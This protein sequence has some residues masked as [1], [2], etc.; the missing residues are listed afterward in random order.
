MKVLHIS[1]ARS[2]GGN[3]QQLVDVL[4]ELEKLNVQNLVFGIPQ[5]PLH[6]SLKDTRVHF[7]ES[8][9]P[10][11]HKKK[12]FSYLKQIV[13][14][15]KPDVIHLHTSDS[16]T[17][18]VIADLL[19]RLRTPAVLSK[20][21]MGNSMSF[22]S[23]Y[24][25]NYRNIK[26]IICVSEAVKISMTETVIKAKNQAKLK[27]V[28]DGVNL[29][30]TEVIRTENLRKLFSIPEDSFILGN[31]A[32]HTAA[33]DLDVLIDTV[34]Y[35]VK[36]LG[37]TNIKLFQIG[38]FSKLTTALLEK[39]QKQG[40]EE[41]IKLWGFQNHAL[42]FMSQFDIYVMSSQREG[43][44]ITIYEAFYKKT[45]VVSTKAGGIPEA[46]TD[47][48]NGFLADVKDHKKLAIKIKL[49]IEQSDLQ[50]KFVEKSETLFYSKFLASA[51]A[52]NTYAEYKDLVKA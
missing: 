13:K 7:I 38:E 34:D 21:G 45:P 37:V 9:E 23:L 50:M 26:K 8:K 18:F 48:E 17:L 27:V 25:Y 41:Y 31:I 44:P 39:I 42:D 43:L 15:V 20:K 36:D 16:V 10:K 35:L 47:G 14:K 11:I 24:K 51:T 3:E 49:L 12:N 46:I 1:G 2:W 4:P 52:K 32:N 29:D 19:F 33:K 5:S 22:L 28:Y 6:L 40:L 30:R